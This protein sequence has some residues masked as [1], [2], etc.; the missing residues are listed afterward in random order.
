MNDTKLEK[1]DLKNAV[2]SF[3][4]TNEAL[5]QISDTHMAVKVADCNDKEGY[6]LVKNSL[7]LVRKKRVEVENIR[8]DIKADSLA[9]GRKVDAEAKR[10]T[11]L[12]SPV[13]SHL[14]VQKKIVD[15][16]VERLKQIEIEKEQ[17]RIENRCLELVEAGATCNGR[18]Y[19]C[20]SM[21]NPEKDVD[22]P[23][24]DVG[25]INEEVWLETIKQIKVIKSE[26]DAIEKKAKEDR[27]A[28]KAR[29]EKIAND[30]KAKAIELQEKEDLLKEKEVE[31]KSV[32]K[33]QSL[34]KMPSAEPEKI[35]EPISEDNSNSK[36]SVATQDCVKMLG[37]A[38]VLDAIKYPVVDDEDFQII[39]NRIEGFLIE[40]ISD[41]REVI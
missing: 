6:A 40:S 20:R 27:I 22:V 4:I 32:E 18:D 30:Q 37:F 29:L 3:N 12:L 25:I 41:I 36:S 31:I 28:E 38:D 39:V 1:L 8:K 21:D 11:A 7:S 17:K 15:D 34:D 13:E 2:V 35:D 16:E 10:I 19:Y 23:G 24:K 14:K 9:Y 5:K 33:I 26:N